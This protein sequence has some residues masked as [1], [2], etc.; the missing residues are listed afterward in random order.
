MRRV[1]IVGCAGT[2][3][4][5]LAKR[6]GQQLGIPVVHLDRLNWEPGWKEV[7][8]EEFRAR[9]ARAIAGDTWITDGNYAIHSFDLRMPRADLVIWV[10]QPA[11]RCFWRVFKR[12]LKSY[13]SEHEDLA[14]HCKERLDHRF[15]GRLRFIANFNRINRPRIEQMRMLHGPDVPLLILR[16]DSE[17]N[18]FL[19]RAASQTLRS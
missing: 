14:K 8:T 5:T 18:E 13:V 7:G 4:S 11:L 1:I 16:G 19:K 10:D 15:M 17:I 3:K 12:A 6:L 9:L 2:G